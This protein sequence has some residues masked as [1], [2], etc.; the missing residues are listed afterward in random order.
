[1]A[2]LF[3]F[4]DCAMLVTIKIDEYRWFNQCCTRV[5]VTLA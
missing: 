2:L 3:C 4:I 5:F 1:M